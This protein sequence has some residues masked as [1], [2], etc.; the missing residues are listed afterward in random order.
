MCANPKYTIRRLLRE[1]P[2]GIMTNRYK[3]CI[4]VGIGDR[5]L[6]N[7]MNYPATGEWSIPSDKLFKLKKFFNCELSDLINAN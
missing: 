5:S 2:G 7:W 4:E 3:L 6:D 1:L